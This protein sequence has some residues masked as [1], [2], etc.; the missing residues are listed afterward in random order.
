RQ[1]DGPPVLGKP[2]DTAGP[3]R[4]YSGLG[5]LSIRHRDAVVEL[6]D[7]LADPEPAAR[8]AAARGLAS[9][10]REDATLL[11]RLRLRAG[12]AAPDVVGECLAGLLRLDPE[13]SLPLAERLLAQLAGEFRDAVAYALGDSRL[14]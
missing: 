7:L 6:A 10:G 2:T 9:T 3:L 1:F 13:R 4:G 8:I 11:L 12:E 14:P 5:L